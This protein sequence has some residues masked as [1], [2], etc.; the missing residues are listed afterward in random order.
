MKKRVWAVLVIAAMTISVTGC[1]KQAEE[2]PAETKEPVVFEE[3]VKEPEPEPE[4]EPEEPVRPPFT[5]GEVKDGVY[6]NEYLG[7]SF[8]APEDMVFA[9]E[10]KLAEYSALAKDVFSDLTEVQKLLTDGSVVMACYAAGDP[11]VSPVR[12]FNIT[13]QDLASA[14]EAANGEAI[15]EESVVDAAME[16]ITPLLEKQGFTE[17]H[18]ERTTMKILGGQHAGMLLTAKTPNQGSITEREVCVLDDDYIVCYTASCIGDTDTS[19]EI[20]QKYLT[21]K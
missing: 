17:I 8:E 4:P 1:G 15:T 9:D 5:L 14:E 21:K 11:K 2:A 19:E 13:L 7:I 3:Q 20:L 18:S 12:S 6:S 10:E 16:D